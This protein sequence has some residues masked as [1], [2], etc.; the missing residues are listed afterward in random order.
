VPAPPRP[1][2]AKLRGPLAPTQERLTGALSTLAS[3]APARSACRPTVSNLCRLAGI[4]RNSL[5]RYYPDTVAAVRRLA[6]R[7]STCGSL[8]RQNALEALRS[9][10]A[11][12]RG[13]VAKLASL[14]DH[15]YT[16]TEE[17]RSLLERR[18]REIAALRD[19]Q[20]SRAARLD[21][22]PHPVSTV[23]PRAS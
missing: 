6:R 3:A 18:D 20:R 19:S 15:Y 16:A 8:T 11:A 5:Y 13:H 21:R 23:C 17:L 12:L 14:A 9:E 22:A 1:T 2:R 4:S 10:V 7:R